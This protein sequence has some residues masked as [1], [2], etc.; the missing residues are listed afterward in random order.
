MST[1]TCWEC[2]I[3]KDEEEFEL[4]KRSRRN[5]CNECMHAEDRARHSPEAFYRKSHPDEPRLCV[6]CHETKANREFYS[7]WDWCKK[8]QDKRNQGYRA[9]THPVTEGLKTCHICGETKDVSEFY[10]R[11]TGIPRKECKACRKAKEHADYLENPEPAKANSAE[12]RKKFPD[13]YKATIARWDAEHPGRREENIK[14]WKARHPEYSKQYCA[15]NREYLSK[16]RRAW[17]RTPAG[18]AC[19]A[20]SNHKR[21]SAEELVIATL[22]EDEWYFIIQWQDNKCLKCQREFTDKLKPTRDHVVPVS[23]FGPLTKENV[24]ALCRSCNAWKGNRWIIDLRWRNPPPYLLSP[25]D[26]RKQEHADQNNPVDV[27]V[28]R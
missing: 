2:G 9:K 11:D 6:D 21:K 12:Y 8:C 27:G 1:K 13:K 20:R 7:I 14:A 25:N 26:N 15:D 22:T 23:K 17:A 19:T 3:T 18:Q 16:A 4:H 24:Q 5:K 28:I 10:F